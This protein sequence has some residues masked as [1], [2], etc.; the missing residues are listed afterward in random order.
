MIS[1]SQ[2]PRGSSRLLLRRCEPAL[3]VLDE[4]GQ[5]GFVIRFEQIRRQPIGID[6]EVEV[7]RVVDDVLGEVERGVED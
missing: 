3:V 2:L 4:C 6:T 5:V 7:E 1:R